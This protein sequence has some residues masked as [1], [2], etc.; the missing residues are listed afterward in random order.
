MVRLL[1]FTYA[2]TGLGHLRVMDALVQS[3]PKGQEYVILGSSDPFMSGVHRFASVTPWARS[4]MEASQKGRFEDFVTKLFVWW[5]LLG[6]NKV[7]EKLEG[8][9]LQ[10]KGVEKVLIVATHPSL[11]HPIGMVKKK[12]ENKLKVKIELVVQVT[13]DSPQKLWIIRGADKTVVPSS[14]TGETLARYAV[15]MGIPFNPVV[16]PYPLSP[17]LTAHMRVSEESRMMALSKNSLAPINVIVPISGAAVGL[18]YL[19]KLLPEMDK[20]ISRF[21]FWVVA[22]R[23]EKTNAFL[24]KIGRLR[25]VQLITGRNDNEVIRLY[26][27]VYLENLIHL[28]ITKPS[29]QAFKAQMTPG[30]VGGSCLLLTMPVG[31]QEYDNINYLERHNLVYK[32]EGET[33]R[34]AVLLEADP[35]LAARQVIG[36]LSTDVLA[37]MSLP[38]GFAPLGSDRGEVGADGTKRFW[39]VIGEK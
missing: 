8:L 22:K 34:R 37:E 32:N 4:V 18:I 12:V 33:G 25:W 14:Y 15:E 35:I 23:S 9:I 3:R 28:E 27:K 19:E 16:V 20:L 2:P 5:L 31:R 26:E 30:A 10:N 38:G 39:E 17:R 24:S 6:K 1:I 36:L 21:R 11:A 29:E 7:E 13:D